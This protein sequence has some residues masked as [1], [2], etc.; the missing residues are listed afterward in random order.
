MYIMLAYFKEGLKNDIKA[1]LGNFATVKEAIDYLSSNLCIIDKWNTYGVWIVQFECWCDEIDCNE[2]N[3]YEELKFLCALDNAQLDLLR[4][5]VVNDD[6]SCLIEDPLDV[7]GAALNELNEEAD[8][9][10]HE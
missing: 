4:D 3:C 5:G 8:M 9:L 2:F 6:D 1:H 10:F 7:E